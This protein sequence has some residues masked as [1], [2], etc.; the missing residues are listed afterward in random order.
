MA[1]NNH[2]PYLVGGLQKIFCPICGQ[3]VTALQSY[4]LDLKNNRVHYPDCWHRKL[5]S[6]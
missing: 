5:L 3:E 6:E 4:H 2:D 1:D